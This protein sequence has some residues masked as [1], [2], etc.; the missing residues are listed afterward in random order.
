[1]HSCESLL[2]RAARGKWYTSAA[3]HMKGSRFGFPVVRRMGLLKP[4][5]RRHPAI[6]E[7]LRSR[8]VWYNETLAYIDRQ[9]AAGKAVLVA[10]AEPL[11]ISRVCHDPER[12]QR[13]YDIGRRAGEACDLRRIMV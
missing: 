11:D 2:L 3:M 4:L 1:M 8:H 7:A 13:V 12:M 9:V 6:Y 5:L 10:P